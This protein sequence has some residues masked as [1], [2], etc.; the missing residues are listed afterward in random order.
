ML[1]KFIVLA[2]G[3]Q[4]LDMYDGCLDDFRSEKYRLKNI[5]DRHENIFAKVKEKI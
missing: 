5:I 3:E 2:F 4:I 1:A